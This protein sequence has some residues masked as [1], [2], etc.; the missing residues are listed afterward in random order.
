MLNHFNDVAFQRLI[1]LDICKPQ[2]ELER[3]VKCARSVVGALDNLQRLAKEADGIV[4]AL[5][6]RIEDAL[7]RLPQRSIEPT[8]TSRSNSGRTSQT[9]EILPS[10]VY[11]LGEAESSDRSKPHF[12]K[13]FSDIEAKLG[14]KVRGAMAVQPGKIP[15]EHSSSKRDLI[16]KQSHPGQGLAKRRKGTSIPR[17]FTGSFTELESGLREL[18]LDEAKTTVT[19]SV[20][21]E[22]PIQVRDVGNAPDVSLIATDFAVPL[23]DRKTVGQKATT[24]RQRC[25]HTEAGD[26]QP[27]ESLTVRSGA[28]PSTPDVDGLEVWLK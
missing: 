11:D 13:S 24:V 5:D 27:L 16:V 22:R 23:Q 7:V 12:S 9:P 18:Q 10:T 8:S 26:G 25:S 4:C 15:V 28:Q 14:H 3:V 17:I 21:Q 20:E 1:Q 19:H 6:R 2:F